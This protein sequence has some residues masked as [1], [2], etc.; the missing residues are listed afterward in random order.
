MEAKYQRS[1]FVPLPYSLA[2][3]DTLLAAAK[4]AVAKTWNRVYC[5]N[6]PGT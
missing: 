2:S 1:L 5:G 3:D 6:P 4:V